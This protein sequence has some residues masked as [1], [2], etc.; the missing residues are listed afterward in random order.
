MK[1]LVEQVTKLPVKKRMGR[2]KGTTRPPDTETIKKR[3]AE[4][5][6][7]IKVKAEH[8]LT[9]PDVADRFGVS[10]STVEK[11]MQLARRYQNTRTPI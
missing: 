4:G 8:R 10:R 7:F 2:P 1:D 6:K 5:L 11:R 9:V 3:V